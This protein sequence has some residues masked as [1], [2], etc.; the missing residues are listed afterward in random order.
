MVLKPFGAADHKKREGESKLEHSVPGPVGPI[1]Q[2]CQSEQ[3]QGIAEESRSAESP[4]AEVRSI[5]SVQ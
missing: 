2:I 5:V 4:R 1:D 3:V